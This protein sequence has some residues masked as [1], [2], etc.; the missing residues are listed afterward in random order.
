MCRFCRLRLINT[1][2]P[3]LPW[4]CLGFLRGGLRGCRLQHRRKRRLPAVRLRQHGVR[5]GEQ[6]PRLNVMSCLMFDL[7]GCHPHP[8]RI[9]KRV[10]ALYMSNRLHPKEWQIKRGCFHLGSQANRLSPC[11]ATLEQRTTS[12]RYQTN[13]TETHS[14]PQRKRP[15]S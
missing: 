13:L 5:R 3:L 9:R 7:F 1:P 8:N 14:F 12:A 4:F 10:P 2:A 6:R 11:L 15:M